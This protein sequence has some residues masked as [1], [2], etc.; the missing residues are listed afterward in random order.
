MAAIKNPELRDNGWL[1]ARVAG[2]VA[3]AGMVREIAAELGASNQTVYAALVRAGLYVRRPGRSRS[4][5][6]SDGLISTTKPS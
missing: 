3:D 6:M 4:L 5:S 1:A 2:R